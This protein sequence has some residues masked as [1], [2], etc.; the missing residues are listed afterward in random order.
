MK[1]I[2]EPLGFSEERIVLFDSEQT[3]GGVTILI[4]NSEFRLQDEGARGLYINH[5]SRVGIDAL[6]IYPAV[7]NAICLRGAKP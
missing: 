7:S 2:V 5:T 1:I 3:P 4:G 6:V